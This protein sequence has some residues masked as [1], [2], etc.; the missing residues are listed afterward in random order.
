[1]EAKI[2]MARV[3]DQSERYED[4]VDF[5]KE[6]VEGSDKDVSPD[7]RNL[8]SVGF[9]NLISAQRSAWKT[10]QA[11]EQNKKYA[12]YSSDCAQYKDKISSELEK[13]CQ[14]VIDIVN[15]KCLPRAEEDDSKVFY[16]KMIGDYYRYTAETASGSKLEEVTEN[17]SKYYQQATDASDNLKAYNSNKLGLALN[18]SVFWYELKND[19]SKACEIAEKALNEAREKIDDMDNDEARDALSIIELLKEN[20]DLWRE[21]E[22]ED[23]QD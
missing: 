8:L 5:L 12:E 18:Y 15:D 11:I 6:I 3:A 20:L 10:V 16:L 17:A 21:E 23:N 22:G 9:K 14:K 2:F 19:S 13:N 4:M 1:M 7:V